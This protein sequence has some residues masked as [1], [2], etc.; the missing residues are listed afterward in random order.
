MRFHK[1]AWTYFALTAGLLTIC[2]PAGACDAHGKED[3]RTFS[4]SEAVSQR[5][6]VNQLHRAADEERFEI[7][8]S[9]GAAVAL[10]SSCQNDRWRAS[11][12]GRKFQGLAED[13]IE[14]YK[15]ANSRL[16]AREILLITQESA[17]TE[18]LKAIEERRKAGFSNY[19]EEL[20]TWTRSAFCF[21]SGP[22]TEFAERKIR[23]NEIG[24]SLATVYVLANE[25]CRASN[26]PVE[27]EPTTDDSLLARVGVLAAKLANFATHWLHSVRSEN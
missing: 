16:K 1:M 25:S 13:L 17:L 14:R 27:K 26:T 23:L 2:S 19:N 18:H 11:D 22:S 20:N 6:K 5:Q 12:A 3:D 15:R 10:F 7:E 24:R 9:Y 8:R 21:F 4:F